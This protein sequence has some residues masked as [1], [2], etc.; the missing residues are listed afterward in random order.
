MDIGLIFFS[1]PC[2]S[3]YCLGHYKNLDWLIDWHE[4][5]VFADKT[6]SSF[7]QS[8]SSSMT[9]LDNVNKEAIQCLVFAD[10]YTRKAGRLNSALVHC[11]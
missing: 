6:D 2:S 3:L 7:S 10:A 1:G 11:L 9:S 5:C 8:H 4:W